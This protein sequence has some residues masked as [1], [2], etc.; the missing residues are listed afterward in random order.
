MCLGQEYHQ[1]SLH[2]SHCNLSG[3]PVSVGPVTG[4]DNFDH[5]ITKMSA[6]FLC[7]RMTTF[8]IEISEYIH[9]ETL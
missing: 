7:C 4:G 6:R 8:P 5:L 3:V 2:S 1:E 9:R